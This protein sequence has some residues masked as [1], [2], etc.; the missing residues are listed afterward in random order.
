MLALQLA[1][2]GA[3]GVVVYTYVVFPMLLALLARIFGRHRNGQAEADEEWRPS[4]T[5]VVAAYNEQA[6]MEAKLRNTWALDYPAD[7][8]ELIVGCDG[9]SDNTNAIL[10]ACNDVRL[11]RNLFTER[12]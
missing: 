12:R 8:F 1:F 7:R 6:V 11:N 4:V 3:V 2:W 9:C 10:E 5:M